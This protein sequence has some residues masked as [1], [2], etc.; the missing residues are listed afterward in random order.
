MYI[1]P[2]FV[3]AAIQRPAP[4]HIFFCL[5]WVLSCVF[6]I[7]YARRIVSS[8]AFKTEERELV[9]DIDLTDYDDVRTCCSGAK[10]CQKCWGYMTMAI[11]V[12]DPALRKDFGFSD[13]LYV[14]SGRRG[15]HCWVSD[16]TARQL[17]NE[18]RS[19]VVDYLGVQLG[20]DT[21]KTVLTWPPHPSLK[22]A[23][24]TLKPMFDEWIA[25]NEGQAI[26]AEGRWQAILDSLPVD[27]LKAKMERAWSR[28][29][30]T[31]TSSEKWRQ[32]EDGILE[33]TKVEPNS[34][35]RSKIQNAGELEQWRLELVL[36]HCYPRL[37]ENV[38]KMQNHLLKSPFAVHPKTGRVCVPIDPRKAD[39]FNPM[40]V[41]T[42][43]TLTAEINAY[44][45]AHPKKAKATKDAMDADG[46]DVAEKE[47]DKMEEEE[48]VSDT[49]KTSMAPYMEFF[50]GNFLK[51]LYRGLQKKIREEAEIE[52]AAMGDF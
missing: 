5:I 17:S 37:D 51:P 10:I 44:D 1:V 47:V 40:A 20:S 34:A 29:S 15:V 50:K 33:Y 35:K 24:D 9:F 23:Y 16:D 2:I 27:A 46:D 19:A 41:P 14:Y 28:A 43:G 26:F 25:G 52:A 12:L 49:K 11:K 8:K 21:K 30:D 3:Y 7:P 48:E 45:A 31:T 6:C 36:K 32:L 18:A 39:D 22:R 4:E 38:S 42:L 13:I